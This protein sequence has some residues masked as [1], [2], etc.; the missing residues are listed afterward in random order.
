ME[1]EVLSRKSV[2]TL[3]DFF[4]KVEITSVRDGTLHFETSSA[5][6]EQ[7][8]NTKPNNINNNSTSNNNNNNNNEQ[9][10]ATTTSTL[11]QV[12][13]QSSS[14]SSSGDQIAVTPPALKCR[15]CNIAAFPSIQ[16]HHSHWKSEWHK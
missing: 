1:L 14:S 2:F 10:T 13:P 11:P 3:D 15:L 16:E 6:E 9:P 4:Q 12:Q 7:K 8:N 5:E